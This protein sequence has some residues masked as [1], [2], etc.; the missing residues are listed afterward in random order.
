MSDQPL[1]FSCESML[2]IHPLHNFKLLFR[3]LTASHL[4]HHYT[5]GRKPFSGE[6]MLRAIIF[7][8]LKGI[9]TLSDLKTMLD[10]NPSAAL[11]CG[12]NILQPLPSVERF[13]SFLRD[14]FTKDLQKI[15]TIILLPVLVYATTPPDAVNKAKILNKTYRMQVPFIENKGQVEDSNVSFYAKTFGGTVFV[16]KDGTLTYSLPFEDK[17]GVVIKEILTDK[18]V[19]VKGLEPSPT[20]INYFK[21]NDQSKWKTNIPSY[22]SVSLGEVY[23]GVE[24]TLKAY[25]KNVE[26][27]FKVLPGKDPEEIKVKLEGAENLEGK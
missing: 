12:F 4:D 25:G 10:D 7:K 22:N 21:G 19:E 15:R 13:S 17:G 24:L 23:K 3:N 27:L 18:K 26:K 11:R 9:P 20:K 8:N 16:G 5:T 1:L 6:S 14:T 2:D